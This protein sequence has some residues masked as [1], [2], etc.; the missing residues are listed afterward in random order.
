MWYYVVNY[1]SDAF[2]LPDDTTTG[3]KVSKTGELYVSAE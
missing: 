1:V 3:G 2:T